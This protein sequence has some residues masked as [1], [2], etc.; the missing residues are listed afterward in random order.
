MSLE[1]VDILTYVLYALKYLAII[2]AALMFLLGLDDLFIDLVY[3]G[4]VL[5]RRFRIYNRFDRADEERLFAAPEKPLA[6]MVPAWNEVGVVG[7]MARLAASTLDYENYQIFVGTYPNDPQTQADVDAVCL[8][9]P[10]VHKVVCARP[11]PTSKADCLNNI[12]DAI[13][14]F[15]ADAKIEFAGF[16]LHD[17]EDVISPL[18]LRLFNYLL[19]AKD[20]I[21]I[22]VYPYAPEWTGF[23]A[24]HYVDEFAENH[25]KDVPVREALT[26]QVPSAGVGT[27]FSRRAIAA[28]LEDG[29]GIAFD[30]QSLTE[31]YDIGF[32]LKQKGMKCIFARYSITDPQLALKSTWVPGMDRRFSQVICVREHFP[33]TWQHAIRQKSRWI[34]GIVF[35]GTRNLGWSRKGMLN[36]FLWRDRRG[37]IAYL[38]S[39]LVNLLF[40]VLITMWLITS[41]SPNAWRF[42]SILEGSQLL[43]VLL[44][45]NGLMLLNR[46]FQRFWFVTRFYG[47]FEGLL[48]APRMMW[49]NFVNF[50]ANL[51]ALKQ[52]MEMGDSRRVAWDKTTHEFPA[53]AGPQR[54]PLG[55]RLKEKGLISEEQLQSALTSPVRRRL[56]R[57]LLLREQINS[58]QLVETL[59]EELGEEWAPLNPFTLDPKLIAALPRKLALRYA[60]LPVAIEGDTL[61]LA[62]EQQFS[63]VSLGAISRHLKRPVRSQ[64]APQG[65]VTLGLR[66]WYGGRHQS[67]ETRFILDTLQSRQGDEA[68]IE[69]ICGHLVMFG[70]LLQVRGMVPPS[71]FNQALIDF[72]P[73]QDSLGEHL[74]KR[75][76]ITQQ[77]LEEALKEQANEQHE[78]YRIAR[79]AV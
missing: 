29:D 69:R 36:Y 60:V 17:A 49:S 48:S 55:Q 28:L 5:V 65:R 31:D 12:I 24:G 41:L 1:L 71:L 14:R 35:Q 56:G 47:I 57:E 46:L 21:Q 62:G 20:L 74:I 7:E 3:W 50:F 11:G 39:F 51:R 53:L 19:P 10:N 26:G 40:L 15:E 63:Q 68:L 32:R 45:L 30:V 9:Y 64:L 79:E 6:I 13:L 59:A 34:T 42:P 22:P 72:D 75:G 38:L 8:H 66:H 27:C 16:I 23:T 54:T 73:E 77:V 2:L 25:G 44:F 18:E 37:L 52:V 43:V 4:R 76:I 33:R 58:T 61:V 67:E 78:A 70:T